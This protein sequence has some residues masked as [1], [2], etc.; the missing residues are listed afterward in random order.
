M[1]EGARG[2][3]PGAWSSYS[4]TERVETGPTPPPVPADPPR[5]GM[6]IVANDRIADWLL[7]FLESWKR[8]NSTVPLYLIPYDDNVALTRRAADIYGVHFVTDDIRALD[9]LAA[10]LYPLS[11]KRQRLR[12]LHA[13]ALP[14]DE[15]IYIDVDIVLFRDMT[16]LFGRLRKGDVDFIVASPSFDYVYNDRKDDHPF[17]KNALLFSD[18]FWLTS[19]KILNLDTV[20]RTFAR[21]KKLFHSVRLK[22]KGLYAQPVVN[23]VCHRNGLNIRIITEV[24]PTAS[25]ETFYTATGVTFKD[26][27]PLDQEGRDI[28]FSHWAGGD[29]SLPLDSHGPFDAAWRDFAAAARA[30]LG[31]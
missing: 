24:L 11:G 4:E 27:A 7:P 1:G 31:S 14:L 17:L 16:P 19:N 12:K 26:G 25:H 28:Y 29:T 20:M 21:D 18:G 23:F 5:R 30:R 15:V 8:T 6:A 2:P 9:R 10:E 3:A 22:L 13:L